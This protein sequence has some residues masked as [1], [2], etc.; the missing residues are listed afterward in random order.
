MAE[1][2]VHVPGD[3]LPFLVHGQPLDLLARGPQVAD[4][5]VEGEDGAERRGHADEDADL[6]PGHLAPV[7]S[8]PD[9]LSQHRDE[10]E[11]QRVAQ[12]QQHEPDREGVGQVGQI[13]RRREQHGRCRPEQEG[14][15]HDGDA[16]AAQRHRPVPGRQYADDA[17]AGDEADRE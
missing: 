17:V 13:G 6:R 7:E 2:V 11:Q 12:R 8:H 15:G 5:E 14:H 3:P 1:D 4:R 9:D 10:A 16:L